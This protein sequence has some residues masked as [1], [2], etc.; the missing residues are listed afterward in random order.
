MTVV[1]D[2]SILIDD[3]R[4]GCPAADVL[5]VARTTCHFHASEAT[6]VEVL[7]GMQASEEVQT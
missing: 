3:L 7:A 4:G 5:R 2:T 6:R 1:V